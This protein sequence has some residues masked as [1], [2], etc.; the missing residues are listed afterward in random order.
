MIAKNTINATTSA[1]RTLWAGLVP[2]TLDHR[3]GLLMS[4]Y[5][6]DIVVSRAVDERFHAA[7]LVARR[8]L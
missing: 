5:P 8:S 7:N 1:T 3:W 6:E 4:V 2:E